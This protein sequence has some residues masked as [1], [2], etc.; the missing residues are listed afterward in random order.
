MRSDRCIDSGTRRRSSRNCRRAKQVDGHRAPLCRS[1]PTHAHRCSGVGQVVKRQELRSE[2]CTRVGNPGLVSQI[3]FSIG[4]GAGQVAKAGRS[5]AVEGQSRSADVRFDRGAIKEALFEFRRSTDIVE[6]IG[7]RCGLRGVR[8]GEASNPG[9]PSVAP[10]I[11]EL[12]P[13]DVLASLEADLTRLDSS[14]DESLVRD[15]TVGSFR[16]ELI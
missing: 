9:P 15:T 14:D 7:A 12:C 16:A 10:P 5:S 1:N 11:S 13:D 6:L 3:G 8:V 4:Q 2:E